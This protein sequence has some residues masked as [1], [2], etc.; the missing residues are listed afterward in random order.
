MIAISYNDINN[1]RSRLIGLR[2]RLTTAN[3]DDE[4]LMVMIKP[5]ATSNFNNMVDMLDEMKICGVKR[6][7]LMDVTVLENQLI[8]NR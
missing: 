2:N 3:G 4:K 6:Y 8:T 5:T 1:L 7:A